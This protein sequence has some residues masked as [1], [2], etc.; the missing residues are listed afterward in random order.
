[1]VQLDRD[2]LARVLTPK[3]VGAQN[4]HRMTLDDPLDVFVL[5]LVGGVGAGPARPGQLLRGQRV[6]DALAHERRR[7]GAAGDRGQ[8]GAVER[9]RAAATADRSGR[10]AAY[11]I[12]GLPPTSALAALELAFAGD[13]AQVVVLNADWARF[14][15]AVGATAPVTSLVTELVPT[16]TGTAAR[17]VPAALSAVAILAADLAQ[18]PA[19]VT[20]YLQDRCGRVLGL[21][22]GRLDTDRPLGA[23]GLDSLMAV[24]LEEPHRARPGRRRADR[25]AHVQ[26]PSITQLCA[27]LL[28]LPAGDSG[29]P[30]APSPSASDGAF[31]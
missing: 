18:R 22:A 25:D 19:M 17:Q 27:Q 4:L 7:E 28:E 2:R 24:Q 8:L 14:R 31:R 16:E 3:V 21:T 1:L 13:E 6:M 12:N 10:P 15:D 11:G 5:C 30:S 20:G 9:R 29:S 26:G 23:F